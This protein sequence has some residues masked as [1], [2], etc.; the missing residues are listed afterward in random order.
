MSKVTI[1]HILNDHGDA[2]LR[3][4]RLPVYQHKA[5]RAIRDCHTQ[6][7][8]SHAD[9]C[10]NNF[11]AILGEADRIAEEMFPDDARAA[12]KIGLDLELMGT[13]RFIRDADHREDTCHDLQANR[14]GRITDLDSET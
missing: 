8:G 1:Q 14:S 13:N 3:A 9:V 12:E 7:M 2:Y 4:H 6:R 11:M 10:V 5:L